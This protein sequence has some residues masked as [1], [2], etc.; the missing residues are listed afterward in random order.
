MSTTPDGSIPGKSRDKRKAYRQDDRL[1]ERVRSLKVAFSHL[2]E[3]TRFER[4]AF[5]GLNATLVV[6]LGVLI[7]YVMTSGTD[8]DYALKFTAMLVCGGGGGIVGFLTLQIMRTWDK[9]VALIER[10]FASE[11]KQ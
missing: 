6:M 2:A 1:D 5:V 11:D 9:Y 4:M 7:V 8:A 10:V 3:I